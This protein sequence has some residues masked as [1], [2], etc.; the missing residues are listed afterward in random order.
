MA[1]IDQAFCRGQLKALIEGGVVK[2]AQE[3]LA[4]AVADS[5][6][7]EM[8]G[9]TGGQLS[10]EAQA[11]IAQ[12]LME[13]SQ[14]VQY[15]D[16]GGGMPGMMPEG[17]GMGADMPGTDM[18]ALLGGAGG[19]P[20]DMPEGE[21]GESEAPPFPPKSEEKSEK[22]EEDK[23][24]PEK[25]EDKPEKSE[26]DKE[27]KEAS[28]KLNVNQRAS[29]VATALLK[30]A[31]AGATVTGDGSQANLLSVA[32]TVEGQE[33]NK[34][35]PA[36]AYNG[37]AGQQ[38]QLGQG[39]IGQ[40]TPQPAGTPGAPPSGTAGT[41]VDAVG[42]KTASTR[43]F[44]SFLQ[45]IAQGDAGATVT[46]DGSQAN[47]LS[48]SPT[49]EGQEEGKERPAP[50]YN[51]PAGQQ[52]QV[53]QGAVGHE[54]PQTDTPGAPPA[55]AAGSPQEATDKAAAY[56]VEYVNHFKKVASKVAGL[57]PTNMPDEER[58]RHVKAMMSLSQ[59]ERVEYTRKLASERIKTASTRSP[60]TSGWGETDLKQITSLYR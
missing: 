43:G 29:Q 13:L 34:E 31:Q 45:R 44:M 50:E 56:D 47:L 15:G 9:E 26:E 22:K 7:G 21:G 6:G 57:L 12:A 27:K 48:E 10:P 32:P 2:I 42:G 19:A 37:P 30:R 5:L 11:A 23:D 25:K 14:A 40:E 16:T 1:L 28:M 52:D 58:V 33:E 41:P 55:G 46:G 36:P 8:N 38:A 3:D 60:V 51:G 35:R 39:A 17:G 49:T 24:S 54:E 53:G 59:P 20:P 4:L 18:S